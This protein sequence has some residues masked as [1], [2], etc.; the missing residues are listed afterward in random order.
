MGR[1]TSCDPLVFIVVMLLNG[2]PEAK[3]AGTAERTITT[4][5]MLERT[6]QTSHKLVS[7]SIRA[8]A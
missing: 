8:T 6:Y 2:Q 5:D 1:P 4:E 7:C 3:I